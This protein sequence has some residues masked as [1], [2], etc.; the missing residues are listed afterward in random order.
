MPPAIRIVPDNKADMPIVCS[1]PPSRR[2]G[3]C[4][5]NKHTLVIYAQDKVGE[6]AEEIVLL[7]IYRR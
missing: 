7:I 1:P 5:D 2:Q 4:G 3:Y 6:A